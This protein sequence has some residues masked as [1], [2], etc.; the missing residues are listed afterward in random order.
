M[1]PQCQIMEQVHLCGYFAPTPQPNEVIL[2]VV[3]LKEQPHRL[4]VCCGSA[5]ECPSL[6]IHEFTGPPS[7]TLYRRSQN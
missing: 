7:V 6:L 1:Y 4:T 3:P 2:Y 5:A